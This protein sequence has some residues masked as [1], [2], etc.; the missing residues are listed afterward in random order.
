MHVRT[1]EV[2]LDEADVATLTGIRTGR[3]GKTRC[4]RQIAWLSQSGVPFFVN[5]CGRPVVAR[6]A[7]EGRVH[8]PLPHVPQPW[9]P[10]VLTKG[11]KAT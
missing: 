10:Y 11:K 9:V 4:E 8:P 1:S 2:F 6:A 5:A 7:V 3:G